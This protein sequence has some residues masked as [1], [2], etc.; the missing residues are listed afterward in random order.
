MEGMMDEATMEWLAELV[1][2]TATVEEQARLDASP[3]LAEELVAMKRQSE[4]LG[5]LPRMQPPR[6]DWPMLEARLMSEGLIRRRTNKWLSLPLSSGWSRAAAAA[7]LF[8]AGTATG[9]SMPGTGGA[10]GAQAALV[11]PASINTVDQAAQV[12][13]VAEQ[14]YMNSLLRYQ[15]LQRASSDWAPLNQQSRTEAL[16]MLVQA[17]QSALRQAPDDPFINVFL[18]NTLAARRGV[19]RQATQDNW[20]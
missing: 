10:A 9:L 6:G 12:V 14:Q 7:A 15:Q 17:S 13:E 20:F 2:R 1:D 18:L 3:E 5:S 8:I 16:D 19:A 4:A 11:N